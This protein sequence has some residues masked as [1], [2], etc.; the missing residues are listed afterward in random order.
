[1]E[2]QYYNQIFKHQPLPLAYLDLDL[3]DKNIGDIKKRCAKGTIRIASKSLR[4]R[5]A[6]QRILES[7]SPYQGIMTFSPQESIWLSECGFDDILIGYPTIHKASLDM[8]CK[9][10]ENKKKII[11]MVDSLEHI[12]IIQEIA[13]NN[14]VVQPVCIDIDMSSDFPGIHFG[15]YRSSITNVSLFKKF[16]DAAMTY[17]N[18]RIAG[19]MG[20]EAQI[21]GIGTN[22]SSEKIKSNIIK[23]LKGISIK[24]LAKRRAACVDYAHSKGIELDFVNG[25]GTGSMETTLQEAC[26]TEVTVGSG[27]YS[28]ALFDYYDNFHHLPAVGYACEIT[29]LPAKN[30]Y[31]CSGGGYIAS[32][33]VGISKQPKPYLP[34]GIELLENEGAGEVQ[35]PVKYSGNIALSLGD[36]ILFRHAKAGEL[37]ERFNDLHIISNGK[38]LKKVETYRGENKCF[39]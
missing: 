7:G 11:P 26:V 17:P 37:C 38:V 35:T 12:Q 18:I 36:T 33:S 1:M 30:I 23:I 28:P 25:G 22:T 32:G 31:T 4:C 8:I 39:L 34:Q 20:Y 14:N 5:F 3:L 29:R 19:I 2:Y 13:K 10:T 15:V 27:F 16:F 24:E 6:L 21:A 9:A